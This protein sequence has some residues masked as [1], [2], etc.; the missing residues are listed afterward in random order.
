VKIRDLSGSQVRYKAS[1]P[2][3]RSKPRDYREKD[4]LKGSGRYVLDSLGDCRYAVVMERGLVQV[5]TG[6]GKGKTTAALGL[7]LR[8]Y[9]QGMKIFIGQFAKGQQYWELVADA[10]L[11]DCITVRQFGRG[12]FI[13]GRPTEEDIAMARQGWEEVRQ[14]VR[15]GA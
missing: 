12:P 8:A 10:R 2:F 15:S 13:R 7:A 1:T 4:C 6:N 3:A 5:Y 14:A 11:S 9:G